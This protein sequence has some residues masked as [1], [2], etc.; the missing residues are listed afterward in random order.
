MIPRTEV[1]AA[2]IPGGGGR[3]RLVRR[4]ADS[5]SLPKNRSIP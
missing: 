1:A 3:L 4:G 2:E 5:P